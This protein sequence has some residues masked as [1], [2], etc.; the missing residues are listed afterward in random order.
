MSI[1]LRSMANDGSKAGDGMSTLQRPLLSEDSGL[2]V[3]DGH[4]EP[5]VIIAR[6]NEP[7]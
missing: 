6:R 1:Q 2:H 4:T 3:E 7:E 5:E